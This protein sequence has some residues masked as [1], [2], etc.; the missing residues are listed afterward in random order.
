VV[1]ESGRHEIVHLE[2]MW[3]VYLEPLPQILQ[4]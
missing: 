2:A 4:Q 3:H 1:A